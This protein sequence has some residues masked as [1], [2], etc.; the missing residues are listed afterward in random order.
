[1]WIFPENT[2]DF[3]FEN[4][5]IETWENSSFLLVNLQT[6]K[7]SAWILSFLWCI[8]SQAKIIGL[9]DIFELSFIFK[10]VSQETEDQDDKY[11]HKNNLTY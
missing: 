4:S 2:L 5:V 10:F 1:M 11:F 3:C 6:L 7:I 8:D 9:T